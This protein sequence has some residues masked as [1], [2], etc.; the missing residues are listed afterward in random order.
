MGKKILISTSS[1]GTCGTEPLDMLKKYDYD[2]IINPY[3]RKLTTQETKNL[4]KD[5]IGIIA[6]VELLDKD[7][8]H[9][10]PSL[11]CIS[12][13]GSGMDNV[14][15]VTAAELNICVKNTPLGPTR[16][17]AELTIGLIF[18]VLRQISLRDRTI[19]SGGWNKSMGYLLKGK[20]VG[21][22]GLGRIG[23]NVAELLLNLNTQVYGYDVNPDTEWMMKN[24]IKNT[25]INELLKSCDII[26][27][28]VP[29][30]SD[31]KYLI[32]AEEFAKMKKDSFLINVARGGIVD[33]TAL[34][35]YLKNKHL[36]GAAI[37][38]FE[39]EPYSGPL[40]EL[41]NVVLTSHVGSYAKEAR[42]DM[43]IESVQNLI[44][45]L[46]K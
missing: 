26:S 34:Y 23:K 6:G 24:K 12:R 11:K 8:L 21:I 9:S 31:T 18:D 20:K 39:K 1:F 33:E 3:S 27:I 44:D 45:G 30:S 13:C 22:I 10:L 40:A 25:S 28:H 38:V 4:A 35:T 14:D 5:C 43:E 17:V 32:G 16:A 41:D 36:S 46:N 29:Y 37:D 7:V 19:R 42:L 2:I 15:L